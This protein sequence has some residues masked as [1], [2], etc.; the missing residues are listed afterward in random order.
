MRSIAF[1][2]L[3]IYIF[4]TFA[5]FTKYNPQPIDATFAVVGTVGMVI[6]TFYVWHR[7]PKA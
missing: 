4:Q 7:K 2:S 3:G 1:F 5:L 6:S